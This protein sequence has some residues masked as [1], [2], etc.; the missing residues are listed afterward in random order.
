LA[1]RSVGKILVFMIH[2]PTVL[3]KFV[4]VFVRFSCTTTSFTGAFEKKTR[5]EFIIDI[6]KLS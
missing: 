5:K 1:L 2:K 3:R 6:D 4:G